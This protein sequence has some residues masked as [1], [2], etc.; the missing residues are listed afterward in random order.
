MK[1]QFIKSLI[2]GFIFSSYSLFS[3]YLFNPNYVNKGTW[4]IGLQWLVL[5]ICASGIMFSL[6]GIINVKKILKK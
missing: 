6:E 1:K 4:N 3:P 5:F 2:I